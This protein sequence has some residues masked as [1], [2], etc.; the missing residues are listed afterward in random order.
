MDEV[1]GFTLFHDNLEALELLPLDEC[2][3]LILA[4]LR[5]SATG[6]EVKL[7]PAAR[8]AYTFMRSAIDRSKDGKL[9]IV[10]RN[11]RNGSMGGRPP[12]NPENPENPD[13]FS[14]NPENPNLDLD[15]T[16]LGLR[17]IPPNG[18]IS[19]ALTAG[20]ASAD[21][22]PEEPVISIPLNTGEEYPIYA[23]QVKEWSGLYPSVNVMQALRSC[24][25]WNMA[26]PKKR[27]TKSGVLK[28]INSWLS[29]EQ[30]R[31]QAAATFRAQQ[32]RASPNPNAT[33]YGPSFDLEAFEKST[34]EVPR[35]ESAGS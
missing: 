32:P 8:M 26:N 4:L 30:N 2:G 14:E 17:D 5:Y 24:R 31:P 6:E 23:T 12:R 13:G 35:F 18:E 9:S 33:G 1:K 34:L 16:R 11:R 3:M 21:D 7:P 27:K 28:H 20:A 10:A 15:K 22:A 25:G 29:E 19:P